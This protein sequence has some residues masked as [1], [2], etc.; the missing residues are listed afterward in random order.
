MAQAKKAT[1]K[2][3]AR[4]KAAPKKAT[5]KPKA[6]PAAAAE[7]EPGEALGTVTVP[8][9]TDGEHNGRTKI[10]T[11]RQPSPDQ[12]GWAEGAFYRV[13]LAMEAAQAG[14]Q[15]DQ[16]DRGR[17]FTE[18]ERMTGVFLSAWE[19]D[20]SK[21]AISSGEV[22]MS[23]MWSAMADAFERAGGEAMPVADRA[24]IVIE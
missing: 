7:L 17:V 19:A 4:K 21:E 11:V 13:T 2:P 15:F 23:D 12:M 9:S 3:A 16:R 22:T 10:L 24:D 18:V 8:L 6:A 5:A 14:E 20:W 1:A